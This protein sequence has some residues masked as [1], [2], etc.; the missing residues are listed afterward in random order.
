MSERNCGYILQI[1]N[2][3]SVCLPE[4]SVSS[5]YWILR[6]TFVQ[7]RG[8]LRLFCAMSGFIFHRYQMHL[9]CQALGKCGV[10]WMNE[11]EL[12]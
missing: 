6:G 3:N 2:Q 5:S 8:S 7:R 10:G 11:Q 9:I 4:N 12:W 1:P